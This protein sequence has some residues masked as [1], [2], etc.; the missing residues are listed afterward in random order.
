MPPAADA[1]TG[2]SPSLP[3][4]SILT[5][6]FN[7]RRWL[8]QTLASVARQTYGNLEHVV[9]DGG[10]DDGSVE[11]LRR[12]LPPEQWTSEPDRG[13]SDALNKAL[14]RSRGEIIGWLNSDDAYLFDDAVES[15]VAHFAANPSAEIVYGHAALMSEDDRLLHVLWV[16]RFDR[17]L[18]ERFNFIVQPTVFMR[19]HVLEDGF[20]AESFHYTMDR[21]LW[22]RLSRRHEFSRID[23]VLAV[24][25]HQ[26]DRKSYA[27]PDIAD[28]ERAQLAAMYDLPTGPLRTIESRLRKIAYRFRGAPAALSLRENGRAFDWSL[29]GRVRLLTRQLAMKRRFMAQGGIGANLT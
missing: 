21:E 2:R 23:K 5:P 16:P 19:R 6:S 24:D 1:S 20:A 14:A 9:A 28:A 12:A 15:V 7:Q 13:Q 11:I 8:P 25:R 27:R 26:A 4:V 29:E 17:G 22:L 10:S 18:L 3:L